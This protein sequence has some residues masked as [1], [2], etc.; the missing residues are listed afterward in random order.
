MRR[1]D[2]V[3]ELQRPFLSIIIP[4]YN[5]E[6]RLQ[7]TL[8][9]IAEF[10]RRQPYC[11]EVLIVEN[12]ST[13][14][15]SEVVEQFAAAHVQADDPFQILLLHSPQGKGAAVRHGMLAAKGDYRVISD[16]DLA[17]PIEEVTK[18]LPPAL[19][20]R[21]FDIAIASREAPG[22]VRNDEPVYRHIMG[23][24]FNFLVRTIAV[25]GVQDTQCGFKCFTREA[26]ELVFPLQRIDGWG[27][28]VEVLHIASRRGLRMV[29]I[30]VNWHYGQNS[31]IRP[32]HNTLSMVAEL[33]KIRMNGRKG[34]YD[35]KVAPSAAQNLPAA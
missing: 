17:V 26:A 23:R 12:G 18:F 28:D 9:Q 33:F 1:T 19:D 5:E 22:A 21:S 6:L 7:P 14:R 30:P 10:L 35:G 2:D 29:E 24:V 27:F 16:A 32:I 8:Q 34:Y 3:G 13:D 25:P 15:T 31:K 20:P 4:A 11:T